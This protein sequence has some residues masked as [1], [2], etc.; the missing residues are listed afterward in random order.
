MHDAAPAPAIPP[1]PAPLSRPQI[2][3]L[4]HDLL[5]AGDQQILRVVAMVDSLPQRGEADDV[6]APLRPRLAILRPLRRLNF[7]RLLFLP[8]DR[9]IVPPGVWRRD[10]LCIPR[11]ALIPLAG[12][13]RAHLGDQAA[14]M[15]PPQ[16]GL[17]TDHE[18]VIAKVGP[19]L[20]AAGAE[21]LTDPPAPGDWLAATGLPTSDFG[22]I[23]AIVAAV[24]RRAAPIS[25][26][27]QIP[28]DDHATQRRDIE[29]LLLATIA[30][31]P[32]AFA[33]VT[34]HLAA[35]LRRSDH[36]FMIADAVAARS[37]RPELRQAVD[38]AID[39]TI[40]ALGTDLGRLPRLDQAA[41]ELCRIVAGLEDLE[42]PCA[43]RVSRK[44]RLVQLRQSID[45]S[46]RQHF[47][48]AL[49][50]ALLQPAQSI[51]EADDAQISGLESAARDLRRFEAIARRLGG[52]D[53]YDR[54]LKS[55]TSAL[56]PQPDEPVQTT[57]DRIRLIE[58]LR[59][60][61]AAAAAMAL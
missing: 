1:P 61:E 23:A 37:A 30:D 57:V 14:A 54:H 10:A 42:A 47:T 15:D 21:A 44:A 56:K 51:A 17:T 11:S 25:R 16:R 9:M 32:A 31:G 39:A 60:P 12:I 3:S 55:A 5:G 24:L 27:L 52:A 22:I 34:T 26:L 36:V 19:A 28:A 13:V 29:E 45:T 50:T 46:S 43:Q 20:W 41:E 35:C 53:H 33:I 18:T 8:L 4:Q 48:A 58:I 6:I 49:D 2:R 59:G 7:V 40:D 38:R